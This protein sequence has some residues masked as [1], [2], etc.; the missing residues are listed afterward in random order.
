V[1][2]I[3]KQNAYTFDVLEVSYQ[4]GSLDCGFLG[5]GTV[6]VIT[7]ISELP[8]APISTV[9]KKAVRPSE[10]YPPIGPVITQQTAIEILISMKIS[11]RKLLSFNMEFFIWS[12]QNLAMSIFVLECLLGNQQK[13]TNIQ[14]YASSLSIL[15]VHLA[16]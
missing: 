4:T 12:H 11:D 9:M 7:N 14:F 1:T 3:Y 8:A 5:Y 6:E 13:G 10:M 16:L 15:L 2:Y